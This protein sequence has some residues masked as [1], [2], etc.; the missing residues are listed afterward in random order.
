MEVPR[1]RVESE[2]Q[3]LAYTTATATPDLSCIC[4]LYHRSLQRQILN[5]RSEAR[6]QTCVLMDTNQICFSWATMGTPLLMFFNPSNNYVSPSVF[7]SEYISM[8]FFWFIFPSLVQSSKVFHSPFFPFFTSK[9]PSTSPKF[10]FSLKFKSLYLLV[11]SNFPSQGISIV[12]F[13][14]MHQGNVRE[15]TGLNYALLGPEG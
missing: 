2:L 4:D 3:L 15:P 9:F 12:C 5:P 7:P 13:L 6:N 8:S 14:H 11:G 1:L 10:Q